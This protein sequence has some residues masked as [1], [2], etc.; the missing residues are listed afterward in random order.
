MLG[1]PSVVVRAPRVAE[2]RPPQDRGTEL[3]WQ[4]W[5]DWPLSGP[6]LLLAGVAV[7]LDV[8]TAWTG[9]SLGA[10][11]RIAISPGLP[12]ALLVLA[13]IGA[14]LLGAT[15]RNL[16]AWREVA[17]GLGGV[18]VLATLSYALTLGRP[19]EAVG[20]LVAALGEELVF[21]VCAV[22]VLGA[23]AARLLGR[24]WRN[25][26]TWGGG[27]GYAALLGAAVVF[28]ALPGHV[29]QM[30]GPSASLSFASLA[31]VLGYVVLR[32][33]ALW[34][35]VMVHALLDLVTLAGWQGAGPASLRLVVAATALLALV[36][37][38][39]V[40]GRRLGVRVRV[41][42][43]IDLRAARRAAPSTASG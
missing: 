13:G 7:V 27:P 39:D 28:S 41:P 40:A 10:L 19:S 6:L 14:R 31:L 25:P 30:R 33:G 3:R 42:Q 38:A 29:A 11:G 1:E 20:L 5:A 4:G 21:R 16:A 37:G 9:T 15:R 12:P 34:P 36:A 18:M 23:L 43:V 2:R 35:A 24:D 17:L 22:V 26:R 8:I 32:T